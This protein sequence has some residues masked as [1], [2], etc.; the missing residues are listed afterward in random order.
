M[1]RASDSSADASARGVL[2]SRH[3]LVEVSVNPGG[4]WSYAEIAT[5]LAVTAVPDILSQGGGRQLSPWPRRVAAALVLVLVAVTIV[6]Y[7]PRSR[8]GSARSTQAA[9]TATPSS[10]PPAVSGAVSGDGAV[11][12]EPDGITG[13]VLSW[14]GGLRLPAA[15]QQPV[16]FWPATGKLM[17]I[18]GLPPQ[19]SGYKFIRV[20]G[21]WAVQADPAASAVCGSCAGPRRAVYFLADAGRSVAQVGMAGAVAPGTA[22]T[23]WLTSYPPG[24]DPGTAAGTA[25]EISTAGRQ[26]GPQLR[27]PAGYLIVRGTERGLLLAPVAQQSGKMADK[28]WGPAAPQSVR[29]FDEV[30]AGSSTQIAWAPPCA[31][32]CGV[33]V[34]NLETGRQVRVELPAASWV[35]SAAFSPDGRFLALQVSFGDNSYDGQLAVQLELVSTA[36]DRL[37][38][39][40]QTWVSSDALAG[41]GWPAG[42]DTLVAEL[43]FT[44]KVQLAS[45][46]PGASQLAI[47]ALTPRH[48][49]LSLVI[50]QYA[51]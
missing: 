3:S 31:A 22:G 25:W 4:V 11:A 35:A 17:P 1:R 5:F 30:I 48:S 19:R 36:S 24:A 32:R 40:P 23:L 39:I 14:P 29:T 18:G 49:P 46:R 34:L 41:F 28:L 42:S 47:A 20:A 21:G 50:G 16:W 13:H 8:H 26:L 27:L 37:T 45:W 51:L 7:L 44:A 2:E 10:V 15:G 12:A 6:H 38:V 33:Q 43:T 9:A